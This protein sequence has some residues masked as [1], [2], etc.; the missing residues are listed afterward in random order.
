MKLS[1]LAARIDAH[2]KRFEND[3]RIN[4]LQKKGT[5]R[6][7]PYFGAGAFAHGRYVGVR[8][9]SYHGHSSLTKTHAEE[10][11]AWLDAGNIGT[12]FAMPT[13]RPTDRRRKKS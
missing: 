4:R 1:E 10:Y 3:K 11:L 13:P 9:I 2:L 7:S 12:H 6:L 5:L 8:Y